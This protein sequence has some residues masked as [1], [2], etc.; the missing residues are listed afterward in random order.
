MLALFVPLAIPSAYA[1]AELNHWIHLG[2]LE[3]QS[4]LAVCSSIS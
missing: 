2:L 3:P 1:S 4:T